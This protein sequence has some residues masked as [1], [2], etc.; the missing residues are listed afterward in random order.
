[1]PTIATP[2]NQPSKFFWAQGRTIRTASHEPGAPE[3]TELRGARRSR[4]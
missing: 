1:M 3:G 2:T 4:G